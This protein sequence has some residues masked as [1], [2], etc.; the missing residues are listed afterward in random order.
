MT[1]R[2]KN[3]S[4]KYKAVSIRVKR[5][6]DPFRPRPEPGCFAQHSYPELAEIKTN[7]GF[8]FTYWN[9]FRGKQNFVDLGSFSSTPCNS[10]IK[11]P[12]RLSVARY[13]SYPPLPCHTPHASQN[14]NLRSIF[15]SLK[16]RYKVRPRLQFPAQSGIRI[17]WLWISSKT[18]KKLLTD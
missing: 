1:E 2:L 11:A 17:L 15:L 8:F 12:D 4:V 7:P 18:G 16:Q 9:F 10:V 6:L 14:Q 5:R 3:R 13:H